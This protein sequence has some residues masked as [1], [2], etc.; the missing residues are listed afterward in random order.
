MTLLFD[1]LAHLSGSMSST[2]WSLKEKLM[3]P[4]SLFGAK[5]WRL[6]SD[7]CHEDDFIARNGGNWACEAQKSCQVAWIP[8]RKSLQ[9]AC[10]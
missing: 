2:T 7:S 6:V 8:N 3:K 9:I 4:T 10:A 1:K 5:L